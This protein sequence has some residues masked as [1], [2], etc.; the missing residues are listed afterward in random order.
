MKTNSM[1]IWHISKSNIWFYI[2]HLGGPLTFCPLPAVSSQSC[3]VSFHVS[4]VTKSNSS[5]S[6]SPIR[7]DYNSDSPAKFLVAAVGSGITFLK[8]GYSEKVPGRSHCV[9][10]QTKASQLFTSSQIFGT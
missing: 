7:S 5:P 6:W 4:A 8:S 9:I 3:T 10:K 2:C 1:I